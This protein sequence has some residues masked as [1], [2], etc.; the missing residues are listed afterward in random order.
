M[1]QT[2]S[3]PQRLENLEATIETGVKNVGTALLEI[4]DS[5]LYN[6]AGHSSF[7]EYC[8]ERWGFGKA[9]AFRL[10]NQAKINEQLSET[11]LGDLNIKE[12]HAR[13]LTGLEGSDLVDTVERAQE[14]AATANRVVTADDYR[15]A[16]TEEAR[17]N[18][19]LWKQLRK[20]AIA[21]NR[22]WQRALDDF[23][24]ERKFA[25]HADLIARAQEDITKLENLR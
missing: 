9:H 12:S 18:E 5:G 10:A 16:R 13:E 7:A 23:H 24:A 3:D 22:A 17:D 8:K 14:M 19:P 2:L 11:R 25:R 6:T 20:K 21:A 15:N 1:T 4:K